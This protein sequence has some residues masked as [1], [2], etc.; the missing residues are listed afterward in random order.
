M[1][2]EDLSE[3]IK[4]ISDELGVT[5]EQFAQKIRETFSTADNMYLINRAVAI[6]KPRQA[7]IDWANSL[8]DT[9]DEITLEEVRTDCTAILLPEYDYVENAPV[10]IKKI[11]SEIFEMEL[12]EESLDR[13]H[14]PQNLDYN[15]FL[16]WF[17]IEIHSVV[18]DPLEDD[19]EKEPY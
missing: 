7:Y 9:E 6:I 3:L 8:P 18:I 16:E 5:P 17:D 12:E 2:N 4:E 19:I 13:K 15:T 14:W 11:C 1:K 10:F